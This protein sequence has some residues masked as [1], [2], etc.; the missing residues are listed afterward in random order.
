MNCQ[1]TKEGVECVFMTKKGCDFNGGIC[2][3]IVPQCEGCEHAREFKT[4]MFCVSVPDPQIKWRRGVCN[5]ATHI[6]DD[7]KGKKTMLNPLK[8]SKRRAH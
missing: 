7:I 4:G 2:H 1:T 8:A 3:M 6:K 5:L